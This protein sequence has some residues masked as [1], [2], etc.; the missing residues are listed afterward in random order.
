LYHIRNTINKDEL[1]GRYT[2]ISPPDRQAYLFNK[3]GLHLHTYDL[4]TGKIMYNFTYNGNSQYGKLTSVTDQRDV[5]LNIKRNFHGRVEFLQ[6]KNSHIKIKLNTFD[7]I[8]NFSSNTSQ[9]TFSFTYVGNLGLLKSRT[10]NNEK[11]TI[12]NYKKNGKVEQVIE[13][14]RI[15]TNITYLLNSTGMITMLNKDDELFKTWISNNT[16]TFFY[17]SRHIFLFVYFKFD[18]KITIIFI[19]KIQN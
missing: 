16:A 14:H 2:I 7:M 5:L 9:T 3:F 1:N 4:K 15:T 6:A 12:Y 19:K 13:D 18:Q 11:S 17:K 10:E 8:K